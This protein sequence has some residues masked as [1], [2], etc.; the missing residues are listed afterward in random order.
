M[1]EVLIKMCLPS[2]P[3]LVDQIAAAID[4]TNDAVEIRYPS[5]RATKVD[6]D[7]SWKA[8]KA[9]RKLLRQRLGA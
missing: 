5:M 7:I 6:A 1:I 3:E 4:L 2:L 9:I 8:A